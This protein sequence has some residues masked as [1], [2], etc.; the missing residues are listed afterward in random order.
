MDE[1][2]CQSGSP[3]QTGAWFVGVADDDRAEVYHGLEPRVFTITDSD[4]RAVV[5]EAM[6]ALTDES[7][8]AWDRPIPRLARAA[9][10]PSSNPNIRAASEP[11]RLLQAFA[12]SA[13]TRLGRWGTGLATRLG[14]DD[15][16]SL[17]SLGGS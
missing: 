7:S 8:L 12:D 2:G 16:I 3:A 17:A 6:R 15:E 4:P 11:A 13:Q 14:R 5:E 10:P 9:E 1:P